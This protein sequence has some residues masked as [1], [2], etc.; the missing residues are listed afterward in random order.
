MNSVVSA[1]PD[2]TTKFGNEP[3]GK[4]RGLHEIWQYMVHNKT[5]RTWSAQIVPEGIAF[6]HLYLAHTKYL[7]HISNVLLPS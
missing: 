2:V 1:D 7:C 6:I 3:I 4:E 5:I